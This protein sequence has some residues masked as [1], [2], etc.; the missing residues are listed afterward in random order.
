MIDSV[1]VDK[2]SH[3]KCN[4]Q[5]WFLGNRFRILCNAAAWSDDSQDEGVVPTNQGWTLNFLWIFSTHYWSDRL[6]LLKARITQVIVILECF[7]V[8]DKPCGED[9]NIGP[10]SCAFPAVVDISYKVC[11]R[12]STNIVGITKLFHENRPRLVI[13]NRLTLSFGKTLSLFWII[14]RQSTGASMKTVLYVNVYVINALMP[15]IKLTPSGQ[16]TSERMTVIL[17]TA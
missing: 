2:Y 10:S 7:S 16:H 11:R 3:Q 17:S 1:H 9:Y 13:S 12:L 5:P 14:F 8:A 6:P 4:V 15:T